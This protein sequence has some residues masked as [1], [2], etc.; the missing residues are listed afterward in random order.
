VTEKELNYKNTAS[1]SSATHG[2]DSI[3]QN[4]V[5]LISE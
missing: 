3:F 1:R 5:F 2:K 4:E